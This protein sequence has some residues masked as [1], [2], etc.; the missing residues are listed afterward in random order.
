MKK[1]LSLIAVAV[2]LAASCTKLGIPTIEFSKLTGT[3][4]PDTETT[5]VELKMNLAQTTDV[6]ATIRVTYR[7]A[8]L[9]E[10]SQEECEVCF[11]AGETRA[12]AN[13]KTDATAASITV[14]LTAVPKGFVMG[15][16]LLCT[17]VPTENEALVYNFETSKCDL[18][19]SFE[20]KLKLEGVNTG[21]AYEAPSDMTI[22]A[23]IYGDGLDL[24]DCNPAFEVKE[25]ENFGTLTIKAKASA[26]DAF[27]SF[28]VEVDPA[29]AGLIAG[30][31]NDVVVNIIGLPTAK[32]LATTWTFKEIIDGEE[33]EFWYEELE[34]DYSACPVNNDGFTL[35]IVEQDGAL[36]LTPSSTGDFANY[37]RS[38][39]ITPCAP[40]NPVHKAVSLGKYSAFEQNGFIGEIYGD[41]YQQSIYYELS[42][43]N[44]SFDNSSESLGKGCISISFLSKDEIIVTIHDYDEPPFAIMWYDA[45][46]FDPE[47]IGFASVFTRTPAK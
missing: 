10:L 39:T 8:D 23:H 17:L 4:Y 44:R 5:P 35:S 15:A 11:K 25:G 46:D 32:T 1:L 42:N 27:K 12:I 38:C 19:E 30:D 6:A 16:K 22:P 13:I 31:K 29:E 26:N 41:G 9:K 28:V 18:F 33:L 40:V 20:I 47:M 24:V 45:D 36:Q 7:S 43:A 34:D 21:S 2:V 37:Y 14:A 3:F